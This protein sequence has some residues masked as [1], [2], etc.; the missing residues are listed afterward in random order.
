M[1]C[2]GPFPPFPFAFGTIRPTP[3]A[4]PIEQKRLGYFHLYVIRMANMLSRPMKDV[5][6]NQ[7]SS[8][9]FSLTSGKRKK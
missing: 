8:S 6:L 3:P 5:P 4:L 2:C 9:R 7:S 1:P